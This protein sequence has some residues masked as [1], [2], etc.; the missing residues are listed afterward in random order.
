V[1]FPGVTFGDRSALPHADRAGATA[2]TGPDSAAGPKSVFGQHAGRASQIELVGRR[3]GIGPASPAQG[4]A[5]SDASTAASRRSAG[6]ARRND[7]SA[8]KTG[9]AKLAAAAP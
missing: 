5:P 8:R 9:F 3:L 6:I 2:P 4:A 1:G 7:S